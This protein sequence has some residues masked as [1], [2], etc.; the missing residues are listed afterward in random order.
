M[1]D[2]PRG[3]WV[4]WVRGGRTLH[5]ISVWSVDFDRRFSPLPLL[6]R[7]RRLT[8][9]WCLAQP[10]RVSIP[11]PGHRRNPPVQSPAHLR[12]R[13]KW[14][15]NAT[16]SPARRSTSSGD[17]IRASCGAGTGD[18]PCLP[19]P[20]AATM[21]QRTLLV[22]RSYL[23]SA[24]NEPSQVRHTFSECNP[25]NPRTLAA[26]RRGIL[27]PDWQIGAHA[28]A[29]LLPPSRVCAPRL[30]ATPLVRG[31][32]EARSLPERSSVGTSSHLRM[33]LRESSSTDLA[34]R[35]RCHRPPA[36]STRG[37]SLPHPSARVL[38]ARRQNPTSATLRPSGAGDSVRR[39]YDR[40][41]RVSRP[42]VNPIPNAC[43][44]SSPHTSHRV[45]HLTGTSRACASSPRRRSSL[46]SM[47]IR[48]SP[49]ASGHP[50]MNSSALI[51]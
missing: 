29:R 33:D 36:E 22:P 8:G 4:E 16:R 18:S 41:L 13:V 20:L 49:P 44:S 23:F 50:R 10:M 43:M 12:A 6:R 21:S 32:D 15:T 47:R 19:L 51:E 28:R 35:P 14:L 2:T 17:S 39:R 24:T 37:L 48:A 3:R 30:R 45:F 11:Q 46:T 34:P 1:H 9:R 5:I 31:S 25:G 42:L 7:R 40:V 27:L 26:A 38:H